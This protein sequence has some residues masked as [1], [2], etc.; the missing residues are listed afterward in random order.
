MLPKPKKK[1][2]ENGGV[3]IIDSIT[4]T[5]LKSKKLAVHKVPATKISKEEWDT[6]KYANIILFGAIPVLT[7]LYTR[8][9]AE[10]SMVKKSFAAN[11]SINQQALAK[12]FELGESLKIA[13]AEEIKQAAEA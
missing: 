7:G 8:E 2:N 1:I 5:K 9:A 10:T 4:V 11:L 3:Y 13:R 12:G 6:P